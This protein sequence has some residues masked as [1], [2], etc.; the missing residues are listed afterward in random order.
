MKK[1]LYACF[2][3]L[4]M[5][6]AYAIEPSLCGEYEDDYFSCVSG[7]KIVSVCLSQE[8]SPDSGRLSYRY[9]VT[10]KIELEYSASYSE[11]SSKFDFAMS[12]Y[13]KG[14]VSE[15]SFS[16]GKYTYTVHSDRHVFRESTAGVFLERENKVVAYK[17]CDNSRPRNKHLLTDLR[18]IGFVTGEARGIGTV[19]D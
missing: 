7:K 14:N 9:G 5:S 17:K 19:G 18:K 16:V 11:L 4:V 1:V 10:G 2:L 15:L 6:G 8:F 12:S 3:M 13:A